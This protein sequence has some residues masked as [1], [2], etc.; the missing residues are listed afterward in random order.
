M[1]I[2]EK[3]EFAQKLVDE[4]QE[5]HPEYEYDIQEVNKNNEILIGI[6]VMPEN[7]NAGPSIY[8]EPFIEEYNDGR[9]IEEIA[10]LV[11][12]IAENAI[13]EMPQLDILD[14]INNFDDVKDKIFCSLVGNDQNPVLDKLVHTPATEDLSYVYKIKADNDYSI[15][16][17]NSLVDEWK[18]SPETLHETAMENTPKINEPVIE[19]MFWAMAELTGM[20]EQTAK[21]MFGNGPE[22]IVVTNED[23]FFGAVSI[24]NPEIQ[25]ILVDHCAGDFYILPSSVHEVIVIPAMDIV[26]PSDLTQ[27]VKEINSQD[28]RPQDRLLDRALAFDSEER[29]IVRAEDLGKENSLYQFPVK[30][31]MEDLEKKQETEKQNNG[32]AEPGVKKDSIED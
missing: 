31:V 20:D 12:D 10:G 2:S 18:I 14:H 7:S 13:S 5:I 8:V 19:D 4:L 9:S 24:M 15:P 29:K 22:M 3:K 28:V 23:K 26:D 17:S 11:S 16:V 21:D 32:K 25:D 1:N 6:C 27:M 30:K